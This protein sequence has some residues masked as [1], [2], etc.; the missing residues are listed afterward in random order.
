VLDPK[1]LEILA[2]PYCKAEVREEGDRLICTR[3]ECGLVY[4]VE[5]GIPIM[6]VEEAAK[7]CPSCGSNRAFADE[8][9]V[10]RG[11]GARYRYEPEPGGPA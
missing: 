11:C 2:C 5:D 8:E 4:A 6:L 10:C 3:R 7:P 9:L 1:L